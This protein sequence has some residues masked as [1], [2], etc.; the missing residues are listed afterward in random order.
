[1]K[2]FL[3][4]LSVLFVLAACAGQSLAAKTEDGL[5]IVTHVLPRTAEVL[6]DTPFW[7]AQNLGYMR[8]EGLELRLEQSFGTTDIKM[9]ATGN[10][11]FCAPG[12]SY[13]LAAIEEELPIKVCSAYDAINIWGMCVLNSSNIKTWEDMKDAERKYGKKLTVALGDASWEMLVSPTLVA[14]GVDPKKD[15]EW[16]VAG[17][18]RYVQVAEGR[19]D[20]LFTW[21]GEAWQ[22]IGQN[23]DFRYI[24]GNDVLTTSS[25]PLVTSLKLIKEEPEVVRGFVRAMAKG[26]YFT[27]YNPEAAAA[28]VCNKFP[29]IDV[30]W[31]AAVF[32]QEGRV[33]QMFGK[34]GGPEERKLLE[35]IGMNWEDKWQLNIKAAIDSGVIKKEIPLESIYT[36]EFVDNSWDHKAVEKDADA[37]DIASVKA[38]YKPE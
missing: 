4:V 34:E 23:F 36:N 24:D 17:E 22:L 38:R 13:I 29:N 32:V 16:V 30:T 5:R 26:I 27:K 9:V 6:E 33:Y 18:N 19:L 35:N 2:K 14:A 20:M 31:K 12:P 1:M 25:N 21:P 10:A 37:Y 8:Q 15:I 3:V 28:V 11:E 7:V